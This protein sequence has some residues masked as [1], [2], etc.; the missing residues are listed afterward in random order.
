MRRPPR[1]QR[2]ALLA[3]SLAI[4]LCAQPPLLSHAGAPGPLAVIVANEA[5]SQ[6]A[7]TLSQFLSGRGAETLVVPASELAEHE[8]RATAVFVLGGPE[9]YEG[10]GEIS[11]R[12][13]T[14]LEGSLLVQIPGYY[15]FFI[16]SINGRHYVVLAGHTRVETYKAVLLF[17]QA[18]YQEWILYPSR[19]SE[20][21]PF[22]YRSAEV[23]TRV[24]RWTYGG[25]EFELGLTVP[26]DLY[27]YYLTREHDIPYEDWAVL[28]SDPLSRPYL[29]SLLN[30][31]LSR[32]RS[33]GYDEIQ[34][35]EFVASFVQHIPYN[36][37]KDVIMASGEYPRFPMET[38]MDYGG[39]CED[40]AILLA[41]LYM[42]MG[43]D[44]AL[45]IVWG[46]PG[47]PLGHMGVAVAL[48]SG[49]G[50]S[51]EV[52]GKTYY[53]IDATQPSLRLGEPLLPEY[54]DY[55][56]PI[57]LFPRLESVPMPVLVRNRVGVI[58]QSSTGVAT[59]VVTV[60][61]F[62]QGWANLTVTA[63]VPIMGGRY[64][65]SSTLSLDAPPASVAVLTLTFQGPHRSAVRL[66][67]RMGDRLV[68][69]IAS[70]PIVGERP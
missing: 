66:E 30:M 43:Y 55:E 2:V 37:E 14:D 17:E 4:V 59:V 15:N 41:T 56:H 65:N 47:F 29:R 11:S 5:D 51:W 9:A 54:L 27:L 44:V 10:V 53:Y 42:E 38:L 8:G 68:D 16:R 32:A 49:R 45:V 40:H 18:G 50:L 1:P 24:F 35:L 13:L 28:A 25:E 70:L 19:V 61:N 67:V 6:A 7:E 52:G 57:F 39:D 3:L 48:D 23:A 21:S 46:K 60:A 33:R 22:G 63:G 31:L 12:I 62:G 58:W 20:V 69:R 64:L 26:K 34:T 36:L